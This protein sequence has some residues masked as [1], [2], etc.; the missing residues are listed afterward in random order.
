MIFHIEEMEHRME[1]YENKIFRSE[2]GYA[3]ID[4]YGYCYII[5][6]G[7]FL[8]EAYEKILKIK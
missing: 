8:R 7:E 4:Q 5:V 1:F 6:Y 3:F 2:T